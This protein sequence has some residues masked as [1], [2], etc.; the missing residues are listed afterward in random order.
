[1]WMSTKGDLDLDL[2]TKIM[3]GGNYE[4][5]RVFGLIHI[6]SYVYQK[7]KRVRYY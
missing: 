5:R 4:K 7:K 3:T 2:T 1:M 6:Y